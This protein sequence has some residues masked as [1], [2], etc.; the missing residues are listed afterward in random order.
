[1]LMICMMSLISCEKSGGILCGGDDPANNLT[2]LKQ[3]I[4]R[5]STSGQCQSISRSTYKDQTV[6]ILS[7]CNPNANSI[8]FLYDCEGVKLDLSP[9]DYQ[10]LKFTGNIELIWKSN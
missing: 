6:F 7:N 10:D 8:P 2:W 1:M 3:E 4:N 9:A 5:L